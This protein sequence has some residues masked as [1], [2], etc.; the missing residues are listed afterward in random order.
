MIV[1]LIIIICGVFAFI[2]FCH[3]SFKLF[4][5]RMKELNEMYPDK[6]DEIEG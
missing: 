4:N 6:K 2:C 1:E 5:E 3:C